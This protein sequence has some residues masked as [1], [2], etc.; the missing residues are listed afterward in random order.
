M[1]VADVNE[2]VATL[3]L[4]DIRYVRD[5][6]LAALFNNVDYT[7]LDDAYGSLTVKPL[8]NNDSGYSYLVLN[9]AETG[10]NDNHFL[11]Q[12]AA[13]AAGTDPIPTMALELTEHPENQGGETIILVPTSNRAAVE[14]L[15]A[16]MLIPDAAIELGADSDR[17]VA[18]LG[19]P[20]PGE[21]FGYHRT[22]KA[23]LVEWKML[24]ADYLIAVSSAGIPPLALREEPESS[25]QGFRQVAERDDYP[26]YERQWIR[27][28][29]IGVRNRVGAVIQRVGNGTYAI[30]SVG[31]VSYATLLF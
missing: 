3:L 22:A 27:M 11:A 5:Y 20:V 12:A 24:P 31:G 30:P 25:L 10:A 4:A 1:T 9:G 15:P 8:A 26:Y 7:Y 14:A 19:T 6:I 21:V 29:G 13:I 28:I 18:R 2:L 16:F 17:L 23:W